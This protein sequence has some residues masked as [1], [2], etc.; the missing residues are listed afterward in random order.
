MLRAREQTSGGSL[1]AEREAFVVSIEN[2]GPPIKPEDLEH[3]FTPFFTTKRGGIG[4][5]M[6]IAQKVVRSHGGD[7]TVEE[8]AL[9]GPCF[10]VVLPALPEL[11]EASPAEGGSQAKPE[12]AAAPESEQAR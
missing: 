1:L 11:R 7:L 4:L 10:R 2:D 12:D 6:A 5:G 9:G 3:I 8:S